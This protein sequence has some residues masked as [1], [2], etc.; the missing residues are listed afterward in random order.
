[1]KLFKYI[2]G[3]IGRSLISLVLIM[4]TVF[5]MMRALPV[6]RYYGDRADHLTD[7]EKHA[8]LESYGLTDPIPVQF[9]KYVDGLVHGDLGTSITYYKGKSVTEIIAPKIGYS[10]RFGIAS[11]MLS[12]VLGIGLGLLMVRNKDRLQDHL[13]NGFILFVNAVPSAVYYLFLQFI[14]TKLMNIG[15]LYKEGNIATCI[16]PVISMSLGSIA[17]YAMWTRRYMLDQVNQDY[18]A[19]ARAKGLT[20]RQIMSR[21]VLRNA[22][23]PMAQ[24]LPTSIIFTIS[25]SLYIES[26][27]SIPGMG[28]L[29]VNAIQAQDNPLVQAIVM[30]YA[31][32]G[33]TGMLLGDLAMMAC[34]PRI[35][36]TKEG[37]GR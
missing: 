27:Y 9:I 1:M 29:L 2:L 5:L 17:S 14:G 24:N 31:I 21:H 37:G 11:L 22:F 30:F 3:R 19:L 12:L 7:Q 4:L 23:A 18:V 16:L 32:L 33:V 36:F 25:G 13:G 28:G 6:D 34:D 10:L 26:L 35:T 15:M 20:N 8:I